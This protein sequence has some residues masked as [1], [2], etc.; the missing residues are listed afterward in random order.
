MDGTA[1]WITGIPVC[2]KLI[3][4]R[5]ASATGISGRGAW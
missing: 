1:A 4:P 3:L 5:R 2:G